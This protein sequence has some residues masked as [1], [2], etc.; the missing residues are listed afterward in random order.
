MIEEITINFD[1]ELKPTQDNW[2]S[3]L[4]KIKPKH[5]LEILVYDFRW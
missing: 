5:F 1:T 2:K 4:C 3:Q